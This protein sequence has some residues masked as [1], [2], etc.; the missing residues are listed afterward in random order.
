[1]HELGFG[2]GLAW[3]IL[4]SEHEHDKGLR[5]YFTLIVFS[6]R[7]WEQCVRKLFPTPLLFSTRGISDLDRIQ[8]SCL[9]NVWR[10]MQCVPQGYTMRVKMVS[11]SCCPWRIAPFIKCH[12]CQSFSYL[13]LSLIKICHF[14]SQNVKICR[15]CRKNLN[16]RFKRKSIW[17]KSAS[18]EVPQYV[19]PC[20]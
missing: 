14:L 2:I 11:F 17:I 15:G 19:L 1:M 7:A 13:F 3:K 10:Q 8:I 16:I 6:L 12:C 18:L 20:I 9:F 4:L 5:F